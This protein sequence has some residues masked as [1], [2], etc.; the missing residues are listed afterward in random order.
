M[1]EGALA[2]YPFATKDRAAAAATRRTCP[3]NDS[4]GSLASSDDSFSTIDQRSLNSF[5][6]LEQVAENEPE[7]PRPQDLGD[8]PGD[9]GD[10]PGDFASPA[11]LSQLPVSLNHSA[12]PLG[13]PAGPPANHDD[14]DVVSD[15]D[16]DIAAHVEELTVTQ[17]VPHSINVGVCERAARA[18]KKHKQVMAHHSC[19]QWARLRLVLIAQ[20]DTGTAFSKLPTEVLKV[21][22]R[23]VLQA[24]LSRAKD[25]VKLDPDAPWQCLM[26][27]S[28]APSDRAPAAGSRRRSV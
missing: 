9:L 14:A 27:P 25:S 11:F 24:N 16:A 17:N 3:Q 6:C 8:S 7:P 13:L 20:R 12:Q 1:N 18:A 5:S 21:I 4:L 10:S 15:D 22:A 19:R 28:D 23:Y 26:A 2:R